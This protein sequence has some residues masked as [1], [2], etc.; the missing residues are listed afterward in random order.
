MFCFGVELRVSLWNSVRR[1]SGRSDESL[2]TGIALSIA[3]TIKYHDFSLQSLGFVVKKLVPIL[4]WSSL[5]KVQES[6][7]V[8]IEVEFV[9]EE[10]AFAGL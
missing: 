10:L 7:P 1:P 2:T 4:D 5:N 9:A 6:F 3:L 8:I